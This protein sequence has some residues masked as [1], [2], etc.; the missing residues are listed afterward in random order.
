MSD[1][2]KQARN[3]LRKM[4]NDQESGRWLYDTYISIDLAGDFACAVVKLI[5]DR[6]AALREELAGCEATMRFNEGKNH[7]IHQ[8][9]TAAE[10]RNAELVELLRETVPA[11]SLA[12]SAFKAQKPVYIKV[13]N[14]LKPTESG[15]SETRRE[16]SL[17][18]K[19]RILSGPHCPECGHPDCN[20]QCYGD[21]MMGASE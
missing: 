16:S 13:K 11:L 9:L 4:F 6:E 1:S 12:A 17:M 3:D 5:N 19:K 8:R 15:A 21:D 18:E 10:Q 7:E 2:T 14:A 20:G